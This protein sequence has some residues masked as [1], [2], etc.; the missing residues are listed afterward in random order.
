MSDLLV[1]LGEPNRRIAVVEDH[2]IWVRGLAA[3]L[4]YEGSVLTVEHFSTVD[5][6]VN[7]AGMFDLVILDLILGDATEPT[8]NVD[9]LNA[10]GHRV[11]VITSGERPELV[12]AAVRAGVLGIVRKSEPD[13]VIAGAVESALLGEPVASTDW[14][15]AI[16]SDGEFVPQLSPREREVLAMWASGE[17]AKSVAELLG[18]ST[19]TVNVYLRRIKDKY[20]AIGRPA[21]TKAELRAAAQHAG[22]SPRPWWKPTKRGH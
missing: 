6:L 16:D 14:A 3:L 8:E 22:L 20:E 11:L 15:A 13:E 21:R 9:R 12:R 10:A 1:E 18:V 4:R 5:D 2:A 17:T 19:N 7:S